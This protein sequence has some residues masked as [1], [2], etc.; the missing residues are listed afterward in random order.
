MELSELSFVPH[1]DTGA[2]DLEIINQHNNLINNKNYD[3]AVALLDD[4]QFEKGIR[5]FLFKK[6]E[7]KLRRL[8]LYLLNELS[9]N[10]YVYYS[11]E[12]PTLEFMDENGYTIWRKPY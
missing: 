4:N 7:Q 5:V 8:Q 9:T 3:E 10:P 1:S 6:I 2:N 12:E 11:D